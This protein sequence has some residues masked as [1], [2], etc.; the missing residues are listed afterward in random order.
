M[1]VR[2]KVFA[3]G[4]LTTITA[5]AALGIHLGISGNGAEQRAYG[6]ADVVLTQQLRNGNPQLTDLV[7]SV[8]RT[9]NSTAVSS[10]QI[11]ANAST[12]AD[13]VNKGYFE[14]KYDGGTSPAFCSSASTSINGNN[15]CTNYTNYYNQLNNF[16]S[17]QP[18]VTS[19]YG[20]D[21]DAVA[22]ALLVTPAAAVALVTLFIGVVV[23]SE[24]VLPTGVGEGN[25]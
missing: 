21:R 8:E 6:T 25:L 16:Y 10:A 17:K 24:K 5:S 4:A 12:Y 13:F 14:V 3:A 20:G 7:K 1:S 15:G 11:K 18:G 2:G 9:D 23:L 22:A 19:I